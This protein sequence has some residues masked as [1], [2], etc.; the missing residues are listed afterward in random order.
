MAKERYGLALGFAADLMCPMWSKKDNF[1][2]TYR[3]PVQS[4]LVYNMDDYDHERIGERINRVL[5][6]KDQF[7]V[8]PVQFPSELDPLGLPFLTNVCLQHKALQE[9]RFCHLKEKFIDGNK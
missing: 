3:F 7:R 6:R 5:Q 2:K 1:G 9:P 4:E 8:L